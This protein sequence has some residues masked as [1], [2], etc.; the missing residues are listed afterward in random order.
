MS[1]EGA[2]PKQGCSL[3]AW[4]AL[5]A[6]CTPK[7]YASSVLVLGTVV[8]AL[9]A[10]MCARFGSLMANGSLLVSASR[11]L[12]LRACPV[13]FVRKNVGVVDSRVFVWLLPARDLARLLALGGA[14]M[15]SQP[16]HPLML[17]LL[18]CCDGSHLVG[19]SFVCCV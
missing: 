4:L 19:W 16:A 1:I 12:H 7:P 14:G 9:G 13:G 2:V 10:A 15:V 17:G 11:F 6:G 8:L 18:L 3:G 5:G